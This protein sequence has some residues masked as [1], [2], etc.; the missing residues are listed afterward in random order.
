LWVISNECRSS[1]DGVIHSETASVICAFPASICASVTGPKNDWKPAGMSGVGPDGMQSKR[2]A[3]GV[4]SSAG[5][6]PVIML[7]VSAAR[8]S[9]ECQAPV[10]GTPLSLSAM[11]IGIPAFMLTKVLA[12][13]FYARQD[14]K[15]PMRAAIITVIA[16]V[17]M[18]IAFTTP[19]WLWD[20]PGAHGG[21]ALA[22]GLAGIVNAWLLWRYLRRA[23]LMRPQPGWGR[24]WLRLV[25]ACAVMAAAVLALSA[26][27]GDWTAIE[28]L[29]LRAAL[30]LAVVAAGA[31][32]YGVAMLAL[33]LR[34]RHLRH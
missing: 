27:I 23:G 18:T 28:S 11:S 5:S 31:L 24:F 15:T 32:A 20:V 10:N 3:D 9:G 21:I 1:R 34:P 17:L 26:W 13:A 4:D 2:R 30:L 12:P 7:A 19:L 16:N 6:S 29:L 14:T 22:T 33:G 25:V 8:C